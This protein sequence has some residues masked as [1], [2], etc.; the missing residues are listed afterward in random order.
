MKYSKYFNLYM[1]LGIGN[2]VLF[3]E[4]LFS[5]KLDDYYFFSIHTSR[6]INLII[7]L[8]LALILII[9]GVKSKLK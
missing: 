9:G 2:L 7:F 5:K 8:S 3:F 4:T 6:K 1:V